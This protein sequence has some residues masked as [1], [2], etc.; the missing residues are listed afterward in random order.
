MMQT[1]DE[2][3]RLSPD[4]IKIH[5]LYIAKN[6]ALAKLHERRPIKTLSLEEYIPLVCDFL[7]RMPASTVIERLVGELNEAYVV[8]PRWGQTKSEIL[9]RID[10]EFERRGSCQGKRHLISVT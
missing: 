7:E 4:G 8:A 2:L 9:R 10:R 1:A 5:H 3:A 6:T